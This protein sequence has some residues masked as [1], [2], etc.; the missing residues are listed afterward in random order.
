MFLPQLLSSLGVLLFRALDFGLREDEERRLSRPLEALVDALTN[1]EAEEEDEGFQDQ[2]D[3][4]CSAF[5]PLIQRCA[6]RVQG[7]PRDHYASVL[8]ALVLEA[9]EL[10]EF[11]EKVTAESRPRDQEPRDPPLVT[12]DWLRLWIQVVRELRAGVRLRHV[13]R[14]HA[15]RAEFALTPYEMLLSDIRLKNYS[16]NHVTAEARAPLRKDAH[17]LILEFIRSRPPLAPA[18]ARALNPLPLKEVSVY[19]KLMQSIRQKDHKLRPTQTRH[20]WASEA[21]LATPAPPGPAPAQSLTPGAPRRRL[22]KANLNLDLNNSFDD[23]DDADDAKGDA[24]HDATGQKPE[25]AE[26]PPRRR[27]SLRNRQFCPF[28]LR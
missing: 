23:S 18:G 2:M 16:L 5:E 26:G 11:L 7:D 28:D 21:A 12:A 10:K 20:K 14:E 1:Q 19:E 13:A 6:Q 24:P 15:A 27:F 9:L 25:S 3:R 8:R 17:A 22:I 4:S